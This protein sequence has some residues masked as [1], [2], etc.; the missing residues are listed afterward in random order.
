MSSDNN[1][2]I[3]SE[4]QDYYKNLKNLSKDDYNDMIKILVYFKNK[5]L[6]DNK[7]ENIEK[8]MKYDEIL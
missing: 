8:E 5:F 6:Y 4:T 2:S 3:F 1:N 7:P